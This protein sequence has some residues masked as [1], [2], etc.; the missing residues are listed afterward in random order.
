MTFVLQ[1]IFY[2]IQF[3]SFDRLDNGKIYEDLKILLKYFPK[4]DCDLNF[5]F[6]FN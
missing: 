6:I 3:I 5:Y 1:T 4:F 2:A